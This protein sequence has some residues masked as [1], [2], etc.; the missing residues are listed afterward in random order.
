MN[1]CTQTDTLV[2]EKADKREK[3][4]A[5]ASKLVSIT[6]MATLILFCFCLTA[7]VAGKLGVDTQDQEGIGHA[8]L[9]STSVSSCH[10]AMQACTPKKITTCQ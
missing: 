1:A 5:R 9:V 8:T 7:C 3:T 10:T 2:Q 4:A 6:R